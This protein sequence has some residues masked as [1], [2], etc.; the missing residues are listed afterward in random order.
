ALSPTAAFFFYATGEFTQRSVKRIF[1]TAM[2]F[3]NML[4][5]GLD[6]KRGRS[7]V[8]RVNEIHGRYNIPSEI[9]QFILLNICF[10]PPIFNERVGWR[11][12]SEIERLGWFHA[13]IDMGLGMNIRGLTHDHDAMKRWWLD[14]NA[15]KTA[16]SRAAS[17]LFEEVF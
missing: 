3:S 12:Y 10:V 2:F 1:D 6:S 15:T 4:E 14:F 7:S 11:R 17:V 8:G 13:F 5:W 9:F 16:S